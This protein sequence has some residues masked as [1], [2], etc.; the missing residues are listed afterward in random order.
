MMYSVKAVGVIVMGCCVATQLLCAAEKARQ[1]G[2]LEKAWE[3]LWRRGGDEASALRLFQIGAP[4]VDEILSKKLGTL[5][6]SQ[7][8]W[9][10]LVRMRKVIAANN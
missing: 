5:G 6:D 4:G 1:D 2:D 3:T 10:D 9:Q 7:Q 8:N